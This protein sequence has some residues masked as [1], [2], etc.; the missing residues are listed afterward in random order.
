MPPRIG[1]ALS[2]GGFRATLFHLGVVRLL[3]ETGQL[4]QVKRI[5]AVSGGSILA[6]H[7]VLHW[8]QYVGSKTDFDKVA[9]ELIQF[10]QRGIRG[11]VIRRWL[12]ARLCLAIPR[13]FFRRSRRWTRTNL[14]QKEYGRLYKD[15]VLNDLRASD[16]PQVYFYSTSLTTGVVCSFGRSGFRW[17]E[18]NKEQEQSIAARNTPIAFAVAAS[19]A[20]PPLF[21]PIEVSNETLFCDKGRFPI[22][23]YLSDGGVYDNLG[24]DK[25]I[26]FQ[27]TTPELDLFLASDAEGNFDSELDRR[28]KFVV[29]RN[30]RASE[31]LMTRVSS[32]QIE[33]LTAL[34]ETTP[35]RRV[36]IKMEIDNPDDPTLLPPESQRTLPNTRTD[37][38]K[39]SPT[40]ITALIAHGYSCARKTLIDVK[41]LTDSAPPFS[42]DPLQNWQI[43][44]S[45][46]ATRQL[47]RSSIRR[48][49]LWSSRDWV[50]YPLLGIV[51]T[52]LIGVG[53]WGYWSHTKV[54]EVREVRQEARE[55]KEDFSAPRLVESIKRKEA[56]IPFSTNVF[57]KGSDRISS[58]RINVTFRNMDGQ[59]AALYWIDLDGSSPNWIT[60][61]PPGGSVAVE[62]FVGQVWEAR[63]QD[64]DSLGR[65]VV[66]GT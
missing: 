6:A 56:T 22:S 63:T 23:H 66:E 41:L 49:R 61:I 19:S 2:G 50:S 17:H 14:L 62:T 60:T 47:R 52:P 15:K 12:F 53:Y 9:K 28:F 55:V 3:N 51:L 33:R 39:F 27:K 34:S 57:Q 13:I 11:R 20:F 64:G 31:L 26:W 43:V 25:L 30:V 37:L 35:F 36:E 8:E 42:W 48:W 44:K 5:G 65:Y 59:S 32:M 18:K 54:Q 38:D 24:I 21:P 46:D 58:V 40:E 10:V 16:R 29:S 1:L 7:L 45:R 4:S